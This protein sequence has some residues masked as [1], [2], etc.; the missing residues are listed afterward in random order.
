L[1]GELDAVDAGRQ[2]EQLMP[3][4]ACDGYWFGASGMEQST[5]HAAELVAH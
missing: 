1:A 4:G 2:L 5:A 3:T